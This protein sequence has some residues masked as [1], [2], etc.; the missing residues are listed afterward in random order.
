MSR[1]GKDKWG[2]VVGF[3][4]SSISS[5]EALPARAQSVRVPG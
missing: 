4:P 3:L 5:V 2:A 1:G